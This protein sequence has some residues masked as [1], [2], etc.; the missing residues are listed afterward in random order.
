MCAINCC[1]VVKR[2][3]LKKIYIQTSLYDYDVLRLQWFW[4]K[5]TSLSCKQMSSTKFIYDARKFHINDLRCHSVAENGSVSFLRGCNTDWRCAARSIGDDGMLDVHRIE[6]SFTV[7]VYDV[8]GLR[9]PFGYSR[10]VA[11]MTADVWQHPRWP[12]A[13]SVRLWHQ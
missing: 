8:C 5:L 4:R 2:I 3:F 13:G 10:V 6:C 7:S 11:W 12:H 1:V 9:R